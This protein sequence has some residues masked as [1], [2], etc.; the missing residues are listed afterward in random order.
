MSTALTNIIFPFDLQNPL[1]LEIS[2]THNCQKSIMSAP[3]VHEEDMG[4]V[5]KD[6]VH[7]DR[8]SSDGGED[9]E[10]MLEGAREVKDSNRKGVW[11]EE[12]RSVDSF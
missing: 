9:S 2:L 12:E 8:G 7:A 6:W 1:K 4:G 11:D 3:W 5:M 10:M